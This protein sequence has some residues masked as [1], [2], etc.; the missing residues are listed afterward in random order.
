MKEKYDVIVIGAGLGGCVCA[1]LL[2]KSG[3]RV[4]VLD[5]NKQVGGKAMGIDVNGFKGEFWPTYG[6]PQTVG[7]FLEAFRA[8]GIEEK[9]NPIPGSIIQLF[10]REGGEWIR[11]END[12]N[13]EVGD[14]VGNMFDAWGLT[15]Q[16][17]R[18]RSLEV[19][20]EAFSLT[21]V[22]SRYLGQIASLQ[23]KKVACLITQQFPYPWLGGNHAI[24]QMRK[25][26]RAKG[27]S[28]C[29]TAIV[30]WAQSRREKTIAD[31]VERL[32]GLF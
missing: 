4:L 18:D 12:P 1:A 22:F 11:T 20:T 31:A 15:S 32:A 5:K 27:A 9:L 7:P 16:K 30:N 10:K 21:P 2:A 23:G 8:L 14:P 29:G 19:L 6:I 3:I 28:V 17:D 13:Q 25:A 24:R 26:C